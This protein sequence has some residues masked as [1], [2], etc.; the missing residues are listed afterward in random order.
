METLSFFLM[1][2]FLFAPNA[3]TADETSQQKLLKKSRSVVEEIMS[4]PDL[5]IP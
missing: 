1:L 2:A 5:G 4:A 3:Y